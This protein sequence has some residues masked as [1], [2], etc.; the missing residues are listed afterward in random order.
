M[1]IKLTK[2]ETTAILLAAETGYSAAKRRLDITD[3]SAL[4]RAI[5]KVAR[6]LGREPRKPGKG[7]PLRGRGATS[8]ARTAR[9]RAAADYV[10]SVLPV[11]QDI[12][13]MGITSY[14]GIAIELQKRRV[15]TARGGK[16]AAETV[17]TM[18]Q[19][20]AKAR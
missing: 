15:K 8:A 3:R 13:A 5:A 10:A 16:W 14:N 7:T 2:R 17:R 4:D 1:D 20:T 18:M 9:K 19:R 11:I 12:Q 6:M